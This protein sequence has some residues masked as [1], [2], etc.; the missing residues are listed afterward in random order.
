MSP[1]PS[2]PSAPTSPPPPPPA[3]IHFSR[4]PPPP[5]AQLT[6]SALADFTSQPA[7]TSHDRGGEPSRTRL[8][9][10]TEPSFQEQ[11]RPPHTTA[12]AANTQP[13]RSNPLGQHTEPL[14]WGSPTDEASDEFFDLEDT[15]D[16][17][18]IPLSRAMPPSTR[19]NS[20]RATVDLTDGG[21]STS[22]QQRGTK[23]KAEASSSSEAGRP[24]KRRGS[25]KKEDVEEI[26]LA[27]EAPSAE[28]ELL[29]QQR[30]DA[31]KSQQ[32]ADGKGPQKLGKRQCII[33][34]DSITN[35][36]TT[37]CG[38]KQLCLCSVR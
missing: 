37:A 5:P 3:H 11:S 21:S 23:R 13:D 18:D 31:I 15:S 34:L 7:R 14:N 22:R 29:Q 1:I 10:L 8:P 16:E 35:C 25:T 32:A 27:N 33:C 20:G 2:S 26:D 38:K 6:R 4:Y 12:R 17:D 24:S 30:Q 36:T 9:H 28:E 19:A